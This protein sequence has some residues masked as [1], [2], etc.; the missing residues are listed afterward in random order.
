[1]P[2]LIYPFCF[3]LISLFAFMPAQADAQD[4]PIV[5]QPADEQN[6]VIPEADELVVEDKTEDIVMEEKVM[7]APVEIDSNIGEDSFFD[8]EDLVPQGEMAEEGPVR[9]NP[10]TQPGSKFVIV[11]KNYQADSS[12]AKLVS[13]ERALTLGRYES[14]SVMFDELYKQNKKDSRVLMGRAVTFQK[15]GRFDEAMSAYESLSELEPDNV[16]IKVNMLGLLSTKYPAVALRRL[17]DIHS[18]HSGH[19]GLA[20]QIAIV[21]AKTGDIGGAL[22]YLGIAASMEPKNANHVY[23]MAIISDTAGKTTEAISYY[24][25]ALEIDTVHGGGRTI[26]REQVYERLS[27]IR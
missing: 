19:V 8:A 20:A 9:V 25:Q 22:K 6:I 24:E 2:V 17:M 10:V 5:V 13:A 4:E 1:M 7:G 27:Q 18:K 12:T 23:N 11:R 21:S 26:P 14:A 3:V 16:D 15:L